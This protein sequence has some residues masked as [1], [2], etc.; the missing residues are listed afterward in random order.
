MIINEILEEKFIKY[1]SDKNVK[2]KDPITGT[3]YEHIIE[4]LPGEGPYEETDEVIIHDYEPEDIIE[5]QEKAAAYDILMG[6]NE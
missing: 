5:L 2:I 6:V 3:T 4:L 1:S